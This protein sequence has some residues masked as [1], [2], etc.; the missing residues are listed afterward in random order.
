[1]PTVIMNPSA[2]D[3]LLATKIG[4]PQPVLGRRIGGGLHVSVP[5]N[6]ADLV[7]SGSVFAGVTTTYG[8]MTASLSSSLTID[9]PY[10]ANFYDPTVL[11]FL[12]NAVGNTGSRVTAFFRRA[13]VLSLPPITSSFKMC[14]F[15]DSKTKGYDG[16]T[17]LT[18][19]GAEVFD[20]YRKTVDQ[21]CISGGY[22]SLNW[23]GTQHDLSASWTPTWFHEGNNGDTCAKKIASGSLLWGPGKP[24]NGVQVI[25][26][27]LGTNDGLAGVTAN[28][29]TMVQNIFT[30]EPQVRFVICAADPVG[31]VTVNTALFQSG[32]ICDQLQDLG[33][34]IY[35]VPSTFP[36][37]ASGDFE[38]QPGDVGLHETP[39]GY[40][41]VGHIISPWVIKA[42][43]GA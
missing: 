37:M 2:D 12:S 11:P 33:I 36:P 21:D 40:I 16:T 1:M 8:I 9:D 6:W 18:A 30:L 25:V 20:G 23:I 3:F 19:S 5:S 17:I 43:Q 41:K 34:P 13:G 39:T 28:Y 32:G 38:S 10:F 42:L 15:G 24:L 4:L 14:F 7:N 31:S 27:N 22:P 26:I 35:R 29:K